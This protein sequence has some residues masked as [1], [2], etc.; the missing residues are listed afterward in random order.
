MNNDQFTPG[1]WKAHFDV[2]TAAYPGHIIKQDNDVQLPIANVPKGGGTN[3]VKT[4][5]A[6]ARL[7]ASAPELLNGLRKALGAFNHI[8]RHIVPQGCTYTLAA[9][10]EAL[11][12]KA[13]K[14]P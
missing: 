12:K 5:E 13:T 1:P 8:P 7:I 6:N 2:P 3:G 14:S 11:I 4:Y 9:E 10:L